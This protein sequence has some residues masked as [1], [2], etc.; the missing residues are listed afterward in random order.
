MHTTGLSFKNGEFSI[1]DGPF[2]ET[3]EVLAGFDVVELESRD[4]AIDLSSQYFTHP[5][6][7]GEVRPVQE[8]WWLSGD[9]SGIK[10]ANRFLLTLTV[11]EARLDRLS[12][13][14][15]EAVVNKQ[16]QIGLQYAEQ[17]RSDTTLAGFGFARLAPA[18]EA[19]TLRMHA[20]KVVSCKGACALSAS[21]L[22]GFVWLDAVSKDDALSWG[23]KFIVNDAFSAHVTPITGSWHVY[24][25]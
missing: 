1:L 12:L 22:Y 8:M 4:Q 14:E 5:S 9:G 10:K 23:Q 2:S 16:D 11:D 20:G 18:A 13:A 17:S 21:S 3:K 24:H 19:T 6:H 15:K 25:G 7:V